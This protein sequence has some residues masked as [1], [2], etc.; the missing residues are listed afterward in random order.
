M[1]FH[2]MDPLKMTCY[3]TMKVETNIMAKVMG[4]LYYLIV[5]AIC[6]AHISQ[7]LS[8]FHLIIPILIIPLNFSMRLE[9]S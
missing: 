6:C 9:R 4:F 3:Q 1:F 2:V 5:L 7:L 8:Q